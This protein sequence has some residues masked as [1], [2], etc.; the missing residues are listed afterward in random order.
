MLK[1]GKIPT[2]D[3]R[4]RYTCKRELSAEEQAQ[5]D[6]PWCGI[7][8]GFGRVRKFVRGVAHIDYIDHGSM[9][10][11]GTFR[12]RS[13]RANQELPRAAFP[14]R[15]PTAGDFV[16]VS[17]KFTPTQCLIRVDIWGKSRRGRRGRKAGQAQLATLRV[18]NEMYWEQ[19][20]QEEKGWLRQPRHI[21]DSLEGVLAPHVLEEAL[22]QADEPPSDSPFQLGAYC[23]E[24]GLT[25]IVTL[26]EVGF[27]DGAYDGWPTVGV[28]PNR[29]SIY[30]ELYSWEH[31]PEELTTFRVPPGAFADGYSLAVPEGQENYRTVE[32]QQVEVYKPYRKVRV[33][34]RWGRLEN[35]KLVCEIYA[36]WLPDDYVITNNRWCK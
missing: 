12:R 20:N 27:S 8:Y 10:E 17:R 26:D 6:H 5:G 7:E 29:P 35:G 30:P 24:D 16:T 2:K 9:G 23:E 15:P 19:R 34:R 28:G 11:D 32:P 1:E 3:K 21:D 22:R 13:T 4:W 18:M 31:A 25:T 36:E 14:Y 33:V